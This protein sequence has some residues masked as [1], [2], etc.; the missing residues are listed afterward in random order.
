M[1]AV[2][3]W[4]A[5]LLPAPVDVPAEPANEPVAMPLLIV[6]RIVST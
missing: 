5:P 2:Y 4:S 1:Q 3:C 6:C